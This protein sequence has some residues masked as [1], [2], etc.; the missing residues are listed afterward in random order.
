MTISF[1]EN[2]MKWRSRV[3]GIDLFF[4]SFI[5]FIL[6]LVFIYMFFGTWITNDK[7]KSAVTRIH[8]EAKIGGSSEELFQAIRK[9]QTGELEVFTDKK[10]YVTVNMPFE[11]GATDWVLLCK[12]N[13][14][15]IQS[16]KIR[17]SDGP[18]HF[19]KGAPNDK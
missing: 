13:S 6:P 2:L 19:P 17:T 7:N 11:F 10:T 3:H 14:G 4:F 15:L 9:H 8:Q 16:L 12:L 5:F 18:M 1:P